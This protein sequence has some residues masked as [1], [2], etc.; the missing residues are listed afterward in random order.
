MASGEA[1]WRYDVFLCLRGADTRR[2]FTSSLY[3]A[4]Q[5][6]RFRTFMDDGALKGG[7]Q[8]ANTIF[9]A[10]ETSR[11]AI[12]VLSPSFAHSSWCLDELVNILECKKKKNQVVLPIFYDVQPFDVRR[13]RGSFG[14]AMV[15]HEDRFGKDCDRVQKWRICLSEICNFRGYHFSS[16][17]DGDLEYEYQLIEEIVQWVA[18]IV[19]CY[20]IF[21]SFSGKDTRHSFTGFLYDALCERGFKITMNDDD[22]ISQSIIE[23]VEKAKLSIIVFS[24]NYAHSSSCLDELLMILECAKTKN[25]MVWPIFY[26]VEPSDLRHQRNSYGK[27]MTEHEIVLGKDSQKVDKWRL[28]LLEV[29]NLKGWHLKIGYEYELIEKIVATALKI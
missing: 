17:G 11:I 22:Q 3:D 20:D 7:N 1:M 18:T 15:Q 2:T 6:A 5:H 14:E 25:Q 24:E 16:Q 28:A 4:L 26:K 19:P 23:A 10:L 9:E 29:A 13:Q 27:A 12:V 8:I 21:L